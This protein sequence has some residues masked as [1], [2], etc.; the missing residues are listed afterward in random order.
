MV[1]RRSAWR[2][3]GRTVKLVWLNFRYTRL[4]KKSARIVDRISSNTTRLPSLEEPE[5]DNSRARRRAIARDLVRLMYLTRLSCDLLAR[6]HKTETVLLTVQ[7]ER[8][9][10][11]EILKCDSSSQD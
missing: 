2:Q 11:R 1:S 10:E 3:L 4:T 8:E 5:D 9:E 6:V 7:A